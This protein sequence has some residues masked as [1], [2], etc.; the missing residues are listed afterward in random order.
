VKT[1]P[2]SRSRRARAPKI[3]EGALPPGFQNRTAKPIEPQELLIVVAN[4]AGR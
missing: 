2:A 4:L 3:A 1:N